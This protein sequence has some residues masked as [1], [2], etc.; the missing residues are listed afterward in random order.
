MCSD[1]GK[2]SR[3]QVKSC[4]RCIRRSWKRIACLFLTVRHWL[5]GGEALSDEGVGADLSYFHTVID[6][7]T[8]RNSDINTA[9]GDAPRKNV[10][11]ALSDRHRRL[12]HRS[13]TRS[14]HA[15]RRGTLYGNFILKLMAN[16]KAETI[17]AC[18]HFSSYMPVAW[19]RH[20]HVATLTVLFPLVRESAGRLLS[21]QR[22]VESISVFEK[23][24]KRKD[25]TKPVDCVG[26]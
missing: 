16:R 13:N 2:D 19:C 17:R 9:A 26:W 21:F 25:K 12:R 14:S 4:L 8:L 18:L 20:E 5:R 15:G 24:K 22:E 7:Q 11:S 23:K 1:V 10:N 3:R 6:R